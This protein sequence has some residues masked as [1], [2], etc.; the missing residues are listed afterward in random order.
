VKSLSFQYRSLRLFPKARLRQQNHH[1]GKKFLEW[2]KTINEV[3][4]NVSGEHAGL[5]YAKFRF[6][7]LRG[8]VQSEWQGA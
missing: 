7:S 5:R 4:G 6:S 8:N 3:S 1:H 2:F